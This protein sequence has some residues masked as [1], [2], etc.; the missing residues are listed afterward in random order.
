MSD[1]DIPFD[2]DGPSFGAMGLVKTLIDLGMCKNCAM[3]LAP[4]IIADAAVS[5]PVT[6]SDKCADA[7]YAW[8]HPFSSFGRDGTPRRIY[9]APKN[10]WIAR[11]LGLTARWQ[12]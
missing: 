6:C 2:D 3:R 8:A 7:L 4:L 11:V 12:R 9:A 5:E 1:D 10:S